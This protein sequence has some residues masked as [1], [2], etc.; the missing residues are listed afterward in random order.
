MKKKVL[1]IAI[2]TVVYYLCWLTPLPA[3]IKAVVPRLQP[4]WST[5]C[6]RAVLLNEGT[7]TSLTDMSGT[8]T[9]SLNIVGLWTTDAE[10]PFVKTTLVVGVNYVSLNTGLP[11]AG[12][13]AYTWYMR[14]KMASASGSQF[15]FAST[16]TGIGDANVNWSG[17]VENFAW[18]VRNAT[19]VCASCVSNTAMAQDRKY[20]LIGTYDGSNVIFY[21]NGKKVCTIAQTGNID[22]DGYTTRIGH[23]INTDVCNGPG[24]TNPTVQILCTAV[25][26]RVLNA[27]EIS[28]IEK[29]PYVMFGGVNRARP[30]Q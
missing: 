10:G 11:G 4:V 2:L 28:Q 14:I 18:N 25:W 9:V 23:G 19:D 30:T 12:V 8:A 13:Q 27:T 29:N 5:N 21:L 3:Q 22:N 20:N 6:I 16:F 24:S 1:H 17:S 7:G 26:N 15:G